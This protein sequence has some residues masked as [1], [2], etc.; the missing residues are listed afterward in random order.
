VSFSVLAFPNRTFTANVAQVRQNPTTVSNVVTYTVVVYVQNHDG[1]LRPGMTANATIQVAHVDNATI[2]PLAAFTYAPPAGA[3]SRSRRG[4]RGAAGATANGAN[5][6]GA[7][8]NG[9]SQRSQGGANAASGAQQGGSASASPWGATGA[10]SGGAVTPGATGRIFVLRGGKLQPVPVTVGLVGATQAT[11][12]P[13]RG[14]LGATDE[15]VTGDNRSSSG[16]RGGANAGN[17]LAGTQRPSGG[18]GGR[19]PGG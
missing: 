11:V 18:G 10:S 5:A 14:T 13:L 9:A 16:S 8:A 12:T 3:F 1:A 4:S 17:P 6:N 7:K 19:G 15:V 2:V